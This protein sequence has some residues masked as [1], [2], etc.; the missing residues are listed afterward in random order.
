M[1]PIEAQD[2][3]KLSWTRCARLALSGMS[4]RMLRSGITT[5]IL[6]LAVA[7]LVY[8][9]AHGILAEQTRSAAWGKLQ[10]TRDAVS[11]LSRLTTP[12]TLDAVRL[13]LAADDIETIEEL[14]GWYAGAEPAWQE[15]RRG[16][17]AFVQTRRWF[18]ALSPSASAVLLGGRD[19]TARL[20]E[21][22][23][24]AG[25]DDDAG[26][27]RQVQELGLD[28]SWARHASEA[29]DTT[30]AN[31]RVLGE[32]S[33]AVQAGHAEAV[34]RLASADPRPVFERLASEADAA[35]ARR[36]VAEAGFLV[37]DRAWD[38]LVD[39]VGYTRR[40]AELRSVL[41]RPEAVLAARQ[42]WDSDEFAVVIGALARPSEAAWW[43]EKT[44]V[45][46]PQAWATMAQRHARELR[47]RGVA[48]GYVPTAR[49]YAFGL[50]SGTLW[51]VGL[52]LLVCVVG[53]TNAL[54]MSVT[55]RFNEIATMKCLGAMDGSVMRVFVIEAL[56]QGVA[57]GA[58]GVL[59]GVVLALLRGGIE[60]GGTLGLASGAA[61][62]VLFAAAVSLGIGVVLATLAAVGPSWI[63]SRLSPMEAMRVE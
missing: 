6:A 30:L 29:G 41:R 23:G 25:R 17:Q 1:K 60:F 61:A 19:L 4:Y 38:G 28:R 32:T 18:E 59:L 11:Q 36:Q 33:R 45:G 8:T 40:L 9:V 37:D 42:R 39:Y 47:W 51:L 21:I 22:A 56:V 24:G 27:A 15:A 58:I 35:E 7:F 48:S 20:D 53:V 10:P 57:G 16:A 5:A 26:F 2:Q 34:G 63:A 13:Q 52:S 55:E 31:W 49:A 14:R 43:V 50:S 3:A 54:L 44:G 62:Q 12:D 46:S